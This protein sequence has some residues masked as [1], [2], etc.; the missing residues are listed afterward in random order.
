MADP[1]SRR[2]LLSG[3][4]LKELVS[5]SADPQ[6]QPLGAPVAKPVAPADPQ[7]QAVMEPPLAEVHVYGTARPAP[8]LSVEAALG[9]SP[10]PWSRRE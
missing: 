4:F 5:P 8:T 6:E 9:E 3:G 7:T 1:M 2:A 10:P